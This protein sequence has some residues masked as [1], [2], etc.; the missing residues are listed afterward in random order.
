MALSPRGAVLRGVCEAEWSRAEGLDEPAAWAQ[1]AQGWERVHQPYQLAYAR[2]REAGAHLR[3]ADK[4]AA[5]AALR[6]AFAVAS[7]LG[8]MPLVADIEALARRARVRLAVTGGDAT[9]DDGGG[10]GAGLSPRELE[11]LALVAAGHTNREIAAQLYISDKTAS[12]H[13]SHILA[14]LGVSNRGQAAAAAHRL[15]LVP[16]PPA[17]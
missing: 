7:A 16:G 4:R 13:V 2:W 12:V 3:V 10:A 8:A 5:T 9:D 15:G 6:E 17:S 14:K 1:A 11:V